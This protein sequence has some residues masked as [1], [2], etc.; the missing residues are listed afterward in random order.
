MRWPMVRLGDVAPI[1]RRP[2]AAEVGSDYPIIAARSFGRGTFHQP[3]LGGDDLTWQRLFQVRAG[4]LLV[5][6][7]KAWEGAV[8]V[9]PEADDGMYCSH[10][11]LT[12][13]ADRQRVLPAWLGAFFRTPHAVAQL[14]AAS[15]GSADRNRTLSMD[16]LRGVSIPLPPLD[17]QQQIVERLDSAATHLSKVAGLRASREADCHQLLLKLMCSDTGEPYVPMSDLVRLRSPDVTVDRS[18]TYEFAGVYSFGR[19]VFRAGRKTGM[20][21]AYPRLSTLRAGDFTYPKLMA[22]EGALG[23]VPADCDGCV[24][25]TE[26]PVFEVNKDRVLPEVLDVHFRN[27]SVWPHLAGASTGT[28]AR[29]RR[30]NPS[31]FLAYRFPLPSRSVQAQVAQAYRLTGEI[32]KRDQLI[33]AEARAILPSLLAEAFGTG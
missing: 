17:I 2:V 5:S 4:D 19:G 33:D 9:V 21:F 25:S 14:A 10:R 8:A 7:I 18:A 13:V 16:G 1:T 29:R 15:P 27:P 12:C 23:V 28:N 30:L 24:V 22:W 3:I 11:Y 26:F 6:N 31:D 20:D 32:R